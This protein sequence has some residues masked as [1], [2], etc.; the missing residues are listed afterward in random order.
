[1]RTALICLGI[2]CVFGGTVAGCANWVLSNFILASV[3]FEG[4]WVTFDSA[5]WLCNT[6]GLGIGGILIGLGCLLPQKTQQ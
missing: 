4:P 1:M 5:M 6:L 2:V 3:D